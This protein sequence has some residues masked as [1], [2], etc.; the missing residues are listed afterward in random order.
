MMRSIMTGT[1]AGLLGAAALSLGAPA[2][3]FAGTDA[4]ARSSVTYCGV[5]KATG[6]AVWAEPAGSCAAALEV[7]S[8]YTKAASSKAGAPATILVGA[9]T[10]TCQEHQG[11][12]NPYQECVTSDSGGRAGGRVVLT[13]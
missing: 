6:L 11:D 8:A 7:A 3:S 10:W 5:D 2:P 9:T 1:A 13:S 4:A 12:P